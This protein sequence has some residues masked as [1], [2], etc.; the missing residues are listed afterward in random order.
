MD[1]A[2]VRSWQCEG[3]AIHNAALQATA[4][5]EIESI[6][7]FDDNSPPPRRNGYLRRIANL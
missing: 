2:W 1:R 6:G 4:V 5:R 7:D 3:I